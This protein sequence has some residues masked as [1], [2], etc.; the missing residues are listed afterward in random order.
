MLMRSKQKG[1]NLFCALGQAL[2]TRPDFQ[3]FST[4]YFEAFLLLLLLF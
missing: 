1:I 3:V 2:K 4:Q